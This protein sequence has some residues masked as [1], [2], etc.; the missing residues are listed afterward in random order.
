MFMR[1]NHLHVFTVGNTSNLRSLKK[2][3][4]SVRVMQLA[5]AYEDDYPALKDGKVVSK[6]RADE[7]KNPSVDEHK[8]MM[9]RYE[10]LLGQQDDYVEKLD[11]LLRAHKI[12]C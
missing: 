5:D 3:L 7:W 9:R 10:K 4:N 11:G 12:P 6:L 2:G 8:A 1:M